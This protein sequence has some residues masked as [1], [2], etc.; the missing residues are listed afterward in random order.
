[1]GPNTTKHHTST[2][3][4]QLVNSLTKARLPT[5]GKACAKCQYI[6][7]LPP[8]LLTTTAAGC[9]AAACKQPCC[10]QQLSCCRLSRHQRLQQLPARTLISVH[11]L[12][13]PAISVFI[14][15]S[16]TTERVRQ[17]STCHVCDGRH[18]GLRHAQQQ[19]R[20]T[21]TQQQAREGT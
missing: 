4:L 12:D 9:C 16:S 21:H 20:R 3:G 19:Q 8:L 7:A 15:W 18:V 13:K 10:P 1:M 2:H 6:R 17:K 14:L 5:V 11:K